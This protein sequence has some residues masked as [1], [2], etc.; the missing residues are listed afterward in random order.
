[1]LAYK[2]MQLGIYLFLCIVLIWSSEISVVSG[3]T[4]N[5]A[6]MLW[7]DIC[8]DHVLI[9]SVELFSVSSS[10]VLTFYF[11][12]MW[13]DFSDVFVLVQ[14]VDA[15][16]E[17]NSNSFEYLDYRCDL[18]MNV[19]WQAEHFNTDSFIGCM[20]LILGEC[21]TEWIAVCQVWWQLLPNVL[22]YVQQVL[23]YF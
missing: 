23:C 10:Y 6:Q 8:F 3:L 21:Y 22:F 7:A 19:G 13:C 2:P 12:V 16:S 15:F 18:K 4:E 17:L 20:S 5:N 9:S 14:H 1:M 11:A